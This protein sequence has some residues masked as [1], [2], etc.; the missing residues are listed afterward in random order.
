MTKYITNLNEL[1]HIISG[2]QNNEL[3]LYF[4]SPN[5]STINNFDTS[6][7]IVYIFYFT[8][9]WCVPCQELNPL[10]HILEQKYQ[11]SCLF[12]KIDVDNGSEIAE[13]CNV[14][15]IPTFIIYFKEKLIDIISNDIQKLERNLQKII[16]I[17]NKGRS[18]QT[19]KSNSTSS[20]QQ[21]GGSY[22]EISGNN[23]STSFLD[24]NNSKKDPSNFASPLVW[25][26]NN[27]QLN[28]S[29]NNRN[30]G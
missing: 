12:Y 29:N 20:Y 17:I 14:T 10:W 26:N 13:Y 3:D 11:N 25:S 15:K 8:A 27:D 18:N 19:N 1:K 22:Q 21:D 16:S 24:Y 28:T 23:L 2:K 6:N 7:D 4:Q 30:I 9:S 5:P